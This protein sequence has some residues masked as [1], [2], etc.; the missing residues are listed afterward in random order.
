MLMAIIKFVNLL[1]W[2]VLLKPQSVSR[3]IVCLQLHKH[4]SILVEHILV[5]LV[6]LMTKYVLGE[7]GFGW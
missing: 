4:N 6:H 2:G 5:V 7:N 3:Y 1:L